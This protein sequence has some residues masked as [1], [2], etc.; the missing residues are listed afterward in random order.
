MY[1][2]VHI[3]HDVCNCCFIRYNYYA[4]RLYLCIAYA[5]YESFNR[6][7]KT[8]ENENESFVDENI[9]YKLIVW[10]HSHL[11]TCSLCSAYGGKL[12]L[13]SSQD[14][15]LSKGNCF[16]CTRWNE[17]NKQTIKMKQWDTQ[18][19]CFSEVERMAMRAYIHLLYL[20]SPSD[21]FHHF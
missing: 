1:A 9:S 6:S 15:N 17:M 18:F 8:N 10:I 11:I 13:R 20:V 3:V 2:Q 16:S 19:E 4:I 21:L 14:T 7:H 12:M 5:I